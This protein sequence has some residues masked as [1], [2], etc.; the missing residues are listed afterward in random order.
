MDSASAFTSRVEVLA[1]R[2]SAV[3]K[4]IAAVD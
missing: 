4:V 1:A 3:A 2:E